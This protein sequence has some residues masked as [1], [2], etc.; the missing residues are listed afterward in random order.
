MAAGD[1]IMSEVVAGVPRFPCG[2]CAFTCSY[3]GDI[4]VV[5]SG[6]SICANCWPGPPLDYQITAFTGINGGFTATFFPSIFGDS[7]R[8]VIGTITLTRWNSVDGS[9]SGD[10]VDAIDYDVTLIITC[11]GEGELQVLAETGNFL[12]FQSDPGQT[13]DTAIP[14]IF[15][16]CGEPVGGGG[17]AFSTGT[18][19]TVT[20]SL[21]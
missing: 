10:F 6:I 3:T 14:N 21:P 15:L 12:Y 9:C 7:W 18:D 4:D 5:I 11:S 8:V 1:I 19:G 2:P 17:G 20:L 16:A 13:I